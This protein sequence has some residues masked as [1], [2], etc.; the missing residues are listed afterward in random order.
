M[1]TDQLTHS[2][3]PTSRQSVVVR[4][5]WRIARLVLI[6]Y[7]CVLLLLM[8]WE[9][10]LVF[11]PISTPEDEWNPDYLNFEDVTFTAEDGTRLHG[12]YLPHE[13]PRAIVLF[14][15]GNAG[16][17]SHRADKL[18]RLHEIELAVF[19]FDYRGYGH[20]EG[21]PSEEGLYADARAAR[22]WLAE[23][24]NI[25][26]DQIVLM[27]ASMGGAV[28][29]DLAAAEGARGLVLESTFDS[30]VD[31]AAHHYPWIPVGWLMQ[32]EFRSIDKI[33]NYHGPLLQY[34]GGQ[35]GVV[36]F[37]NGERLFAAANGPN[38]QFIVDP[39]A[40]HGRRRG[41]EYE[42]ALDAFFDQFASDTRTNP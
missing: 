35:D 15:H 27:G 39:D 34:H 16:N 1:A 5:A 7:L 36:P 18:R 10:R 20:S 33:G 24:E 31:T 37:E 22:A 23:R 30:L 19:A 11:L 38:K 21:Q 41:M 25:A 9:Q 4:W 40:K 32:N 29:I 14:A 6:P 3:A 12:W 28:L 2:E 13:N 17:L 26:E 8:Q 42:Q